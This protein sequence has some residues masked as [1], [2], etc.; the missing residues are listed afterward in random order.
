MIRCQT[1]NA[2]TSLFFNKRYCHISKKA[3]NDSFSE[4]ID[5]RSLA[6]ELCRQVEAIGGI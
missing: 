5:K 3:P 4:G 1:A 2:S 6:G